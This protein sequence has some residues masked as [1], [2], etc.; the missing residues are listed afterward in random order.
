MHYSYVHYVHTLLT[1]YANMHN[2]YLR[3]SNSVHLGLANVYV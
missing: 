2:A 1:D 3:S